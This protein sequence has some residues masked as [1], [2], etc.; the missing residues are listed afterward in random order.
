MMDC[1]A[2][3]AR[4]YTYLDGELDAAGCAEVQ[5]HLEACS[6][7]VDHA[8]FE[9]AVLQLVRAKCCEPAPEGLLERLRTALNDVR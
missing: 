7:C 6:G 8:G 9:E 5:A 2:L 1:N 3:I 4:L